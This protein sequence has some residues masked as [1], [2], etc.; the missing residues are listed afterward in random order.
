MVGLGVDGPASNETGVLLPELR[1][2]LYFA[3][4][5]SGR[6]DALTSAEALELGTFRGAACLG[7]ADLGRIELGAPAD[8]AVWPAEDIEDVPE[9]ADGL[10]LGPDRR[11]R[12]LLVAGE[13]VVRD[14]SLLGVDLHD[15]HAELARRSRGLWE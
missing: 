10:V 1:Q 11:A 3:R 15:A 4:Q 12:H 13:E 2:A 5:R 14:G 7:R 9:P 6:P 8:L